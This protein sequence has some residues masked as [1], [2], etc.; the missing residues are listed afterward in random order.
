VRLYVHLKCPAPIDS[1]AHTPPAGTRLHAS[2]Q[3]EPIDCVPK[4]TV[5]AAPCASAAGGAAHIRA[6]LRRVTSPRVS[7]RVRR[8]MVSLRHVRVRRFSRRGWAWVGLIF[9][10][11][12]F[13]FCMPSGVRSRCQG[14]SGYCERLRFRQSPRPWAGMPR[15]ATRCGTSAMRCEASIGFGRRQ[16]RAR[17]SPRWPRC[18]GEQTVRRR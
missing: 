18:C 12:H 13:S 5:G 2:T 8:P 10:A 15:C 4:A 1:V 16:W 7:E 11:R 17:R 14:Y 3:Y 9:A 6:A